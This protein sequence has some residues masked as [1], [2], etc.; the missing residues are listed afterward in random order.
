MHQSTLFSFYFCVIAIIFIF[1]RANKPISNKNRLIVLTDTI[2]WL[3]FSFFYKSSAVRSRSSSINSF[4]LWP[5]YSPITFGRPYFFFGI[6]VPNILNYWFHLEIVEK[7]IFIS[8]SFNCSDI[9]LY[10]KPDIYKPKAKPFSNGEWFY[11]I[12]L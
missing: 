4:I 3:I 5:V 2:L 12:I 11:Y 9:F 6:N 8:L 10:D 1:L 7:W